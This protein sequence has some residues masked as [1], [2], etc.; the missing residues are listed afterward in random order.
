MGKKTSVVGKSGVYYLNQVVKIIPGKT[1]TK[2]SI[3]IIGE[4]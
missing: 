4:V 1:T 3:G 2:D